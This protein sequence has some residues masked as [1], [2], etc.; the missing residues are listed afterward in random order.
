[1][2]ISFP[3]GRASEVRVEIEAMEGDLPQFSARSDFKTSQ[4]KLS[5]H[6]KTLFA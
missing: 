5:N 3:V 1:L 2:K 6:Y 4:K